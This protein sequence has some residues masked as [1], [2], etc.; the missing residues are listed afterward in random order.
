MWLIIQADY[1]SKGAVNK[2][3]ISTLQDRSSNLIDRKREFFKQIHFLLCKSCLWCASYLSLSSNSIS[4]AKCP[5]C[6]NKLE[7]MQMQISNVDYS[8]LGHCFQRNC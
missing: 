3:F 1:G 5:M 8:K 6:S 7:W 2:G 4:I